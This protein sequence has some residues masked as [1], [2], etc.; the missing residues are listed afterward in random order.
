MEEGR[1]GKDGRI[2]KRLVRGRTEHGR[3]AN[4]KLGGKVI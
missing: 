2:W 1:Q 4:E 3:E